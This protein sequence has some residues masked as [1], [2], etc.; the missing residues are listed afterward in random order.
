MAE[1]LDA[2]AGKVE[3]PEGV[4]ANIINGDKRTEK[5]RDE[6]I[7]NG[8]LYADEERKERP[9]AVDR[10]ERKFRSRSP[11]GDSRGVARKASPG[12]RES[13]HS[14]SRSGSP[15]YSPRPVRVRQSRSRSA[16]GARGEGANKR[17]YSPEIDTP[18]T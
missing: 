17:A 16:E 7:P 11:S 4:R 15:R 2:K 5:Y 10:D 18:Y 12:Y 3:N 13:L 14:R 8:K 9:H 6:D 1:K